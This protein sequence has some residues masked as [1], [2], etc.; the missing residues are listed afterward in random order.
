MRSGCTSSPRCAPSFQASRH[1]NR[2]SP[3]SG[4]G[5]PSAPGRAPSPSWSV[6][7]TTCRDCRA[8]CVEQTACVGCAAASGLAACP[9]S[10]R[11][12]PGQPPSRGRMATVTATTYAP[13]PRAPTPRR[14]RPG[15]PP[16]ARLPKSIGRPARIPCPCLSNPIWPPPPPQAQRGNGRFPSCGPRQTRPAGSSTRPTPIACAARAWTRRAGVASSHLPAGAATT[17][18]RPFASLMYVQPPSVR[19]AG[20]KRT[21]PPKTKKTGQSPAR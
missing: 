6:S 20:R 11:K 1:P 3:P 8:A 9:H 17:M 12:R 15:L 5:V 18:G 16:V 4:V 21:P 7:S 2:P 10:K 14:Q 19:C 13:T